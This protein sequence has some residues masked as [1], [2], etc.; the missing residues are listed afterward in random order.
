MIKE[1]LIV[2]G[3]LIGC[4]YLYLLDK[5][6]NPNIVIGFISCMLLLYCGLI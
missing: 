2:L 6:R 3:A 1:I 4:Y 5:K